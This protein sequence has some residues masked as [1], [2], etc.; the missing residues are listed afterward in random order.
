M[1]T[2]PTLFV[3]H[4]SPM[5]ALVPG[6]AGAVWQAIAAD[7]P[8]PRAV[9]VVSAHWETGLPMLSST[10]RHSTMHDFS[11]F[12]E[13]LY[14]LRYDAPGAPEVAREAA[15]LLATAG[16]VPALNGCRGLDHGAWV[17]LRWMYPARDVPVLELSVQTALGT[18][19]HL[20]LG[21]ALAPL[22][23][24]GVL[25][26]GSGHVTHNLHDWMRR[27]RDPLPLP[28]VHEFAQ[29]LA[30]TLEAG[31]RTA[32]V[33]YRARAPSAVRAH[34]TEEHFL[35]LYVA[36]GAAGPGARAVRAHAGTEGNALSMDAWRFEP[37]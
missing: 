20:R 2:L 10:A 12:P 1:A 11:G 8:R 5:H 28:Y 9:L 23:R 37:A 33:D 22:A 6:E 25:V 32:L 7:L 35:P 24:D 36:L 13:P 26:L 34:P 16:H 18:E 4:G 21:E 15:A 14:E 31:D 3:S 27:Q 17:P 29:W 19:H 30:A